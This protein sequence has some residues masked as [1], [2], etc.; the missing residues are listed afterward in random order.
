MPFHYLRDV[1]RICLLTICVF[2]FSLV[3]LLGA[4]E[5]AAVKLLCEYKVDPLGID[6]TNPRLSW[7][8]E[9]SAEGV[10]QEAYQV[11]VSASRE[12]LAEDRDLVWD[13]GKVMSSQSIHIRY[14]GR[15]TE[16][17]HRYFWKVRIWTGDQ[18]SGWSEPAYWEMGLLQASDWKASWIES[19]REEDPDRSEPSPM[20]RRDFTLDKSPVRARLYIT[21]RGLYQAEINGDIVGDQVLTPGWTSYNKRLQYQTYDV[22]D[23]LK[24]GDNAIGVRLG[25]GWYRGFI[26]FRGNRNAYGDHLGLLCQLE[27]TSEDGNTEIIESDTNWK[28]STGPVLASDIYNGEVYDARLEKDGWSEA[29]FDDNAW[30]PVRLGSVSSTNLIASAGPPVRRIEEIKPVKILKTPEGDTVVDMGQNMV[31]RIRMEVSGEAGTK[32]I[33]RHAEVL[34][35]DGNFY[36]ENLRAAL[37]RLEYT[38]KGEG[39]EVYEPLFT[40]QGF[41]YVAVEGYP[42]DLTT[43]SLAGIVIHSDMVPTGSF[44]CSNPLIN[45]LQHN[46][47]WGQKG[48]FLDVPTDCPQRDER[49]GWTGDAQVFAE[50]ANF[51]FNAASFY[52]KWLGD[53]A[54]DQLDDGQVPHVVPNVLRGFSATGWADAAVIIPWTM[55]VQ[56]GDEGILEQQYDSMAAW[57][58]YM[59]KQAGNSYLW[60]NGTHYGDWLAYATTRS[61]YPGATTDKDL[62]ATAFFAYS[63][64]LMEKTA[65]VLGRYEDAERYASL[66]KRIQQA[67]VQEYVTENG[68]MASNTQTAYTIAL[69]FGLLP[70]GLRAQAVDRLA[71]DVRA[72]NNHLTTGFLGTPY[73]CHVLSSNGK[74]GVAYDLL[75]QETYPS[76]LYP[77]KMGATTIW[78]R[79]DGIKPDGSFQDAGMN[80]YNHYAY[81]AIGSWL[82]GVVAGIQPDPDEPGFRHIN[83]S[84]EPGGGMT[85]ARA[86]LDSMYGTIKSGWKLEDGKFTMDVQVPPNTRATVKLPEARLGTVVLNG[87]PIQEQTRYNPRQAGNSVILEVLSGEY[88]FTYNPAA[89]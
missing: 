59:K 64:S 58:E 82:Y 78:E 66:W 81:G 6:T 34:D 54:A 87:S 5:P 75:N 45:Q 48:N 74:T 65:R 2:L 52:T 7:Q 18:E 49:L 46:I 27:V 62:L 63:T 15:E 19:T 4:A 76:W 77:V 40:F 11:M 29:G 35:K 71:A 30:N 68:R 88:E 42:G 61:D 28:A 44:E 16:S 33:L 12:G 89:F 26:A 84:P 31:G 67:F 80:S 53:V 55:Y 36:T 22:T 72:F 39:T 21:S 3:Q 70:R 20:M 73:L 25:D 56:F 83:I 43:D 24:K 10:M 86:E 57:V 69:K 17:R 23:L 38:L 47:T 51:N 41:R 8:I 85:Y 32:V 37:Q 14:Q 9:T 60:T 13:T 50:T 1:R 79:W